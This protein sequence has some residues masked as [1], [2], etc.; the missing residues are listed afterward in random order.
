[1]GEGTSSF[2]SCRQLTRKINKNRS[3]IQR[4]LRD[5]SSHMREVGETLLLEICMC[6]NEKRKTSALLWASRTPK[7]AR[8]QRAV[9]SSLKTPALSVS[10][11]YWDCLWRKHPSRNSSVEKAMATHSSVL[12]WRTPW[13]E[14]PGGLPSMGSH[15]VR[16]DW[17]DLAMA[18]A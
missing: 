13:T 18:A 1:M 14:E 5:V 7:G 12:A 6:W 10:D 8:Q 4:G 11:Q 9:L 16:H 17:S 15:R 2:S 3:N